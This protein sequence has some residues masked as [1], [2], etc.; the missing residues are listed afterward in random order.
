[1]KLGFV[2]IYVNDV[3][4]VLK[5]YRQAFNLNVRLEHEESGELLYGEMET[6][7]AILGF[8]SHA[9]GELNLNVEYQKISSQG[10]PFGQEIVF[11]CEDVEATYRRALDAG[12][13]PISP[14]TEKP[15]G[16]TVAYLRSIEGTLLELCTE[17]NA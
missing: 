7:G 4:P 12:A 14:P 3:R 13:S 9:M 8:A 11:L 5:F 6:Q 1:M 17:M 2:V 10:K 15:W 16:Q